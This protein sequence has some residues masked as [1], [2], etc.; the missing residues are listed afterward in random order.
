MTWTWLG[1]FLHIN[2]T[3]L[4]D[5]FSLPSSFKANHSTSLSIKST[6]LSKSMMAKCKC[7]FFFAKYFWCNCL[8][9]KMEFLVPHPGMKPKWI[10]PFYS[11]CL[12][13]FLITLSFIFRIWSVNFFLLRR[14]YY[15]SLSFS[16]LLLNHLLSPYRSL[17]WF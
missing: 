16:F 17:K 14:L 1:T 3:I 2:C 4:T 13:N 9:M 11:C 5:H 12:I 7:F 6:A 10:S 8:K 15:S